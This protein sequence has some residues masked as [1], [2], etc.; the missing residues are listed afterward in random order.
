MHTQTRIFCMPSEL[1]LTV[2]AIELALWLACSLSVCAVPLF[3]CLT[4]YRG[5]CFG[6]TLAMLT[7]G[8]L[9][10]PDTLPLAAYAAVTLVML[11][12]AAGTKP[13]PKAIARFLPCA[14]MAFGILLMG[15]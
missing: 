3:A 5:T 7:A 2:P 15:K 6:F 11:I 10:A 12:F 4:L 14:G 9:N 8:T 13:H 1:T